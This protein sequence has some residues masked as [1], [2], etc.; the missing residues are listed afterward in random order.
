MIFCW[1]IEN[2]ESKN[3]ICKKEKKEKLILI[4]SGKS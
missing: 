2:P 4:K 1:Y 3:D